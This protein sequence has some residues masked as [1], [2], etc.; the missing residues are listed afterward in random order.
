MA[1]GVSI[2]AILPRASQE[3]FSI[4]SLVNIVYWP[5]YGEIRILDRLDKCFEDPENCKNMNEANASLVLLTIYM[6]IASVL[7]LNLLIAMFR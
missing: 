7:L 5:I 4:K 1:F 6:M 3:S 2:G